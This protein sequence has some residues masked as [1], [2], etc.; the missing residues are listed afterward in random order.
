MRVIRKIFRGAWHYLWVC[1]L[2]PCGG[3]AGSNSVM[4][5]FMNRNSVVEL[6]ESRLE[7]CD[8][9]TEMFAH[10]IRSVSLLTRLG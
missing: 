5:K 3:Y 10:S 8:Q 4:G 6:K 2:L 7:H 1:S 9:S